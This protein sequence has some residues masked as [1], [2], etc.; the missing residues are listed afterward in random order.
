[1]SAIKMGSDWYYVSKL[2][3]SCADTKYLVHSEGAGFMAN[4]GKDVVPAHPWYFDGLLFRD[5]TERVHIG[6]PKESAAVGYFAFAAGPDKYII[7]LVGLGDPLLARLQ[8]A[9][10]AYYLP[11]DWHSGHF[12]RMEPIGYRESVRDGNNQL[13]EPGLNEY[14][15]HLLTIIRG[16]IFSWERFK[17]IY[18]MNMGHYDHLLDYYND[19]IKKARRVGIL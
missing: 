3:P 1:M 11:D 15:D 8:P 12:Y 2:N 5:L 6:G 13:E 9:N 7:D 4:L 18:H 10:T 19:N 14:Y 16:P 17:V